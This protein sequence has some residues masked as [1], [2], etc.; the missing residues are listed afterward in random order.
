C[1]RSTESAPARGGLGGLLYTGW[2]TTS[3][4][5]SQVRCPACGHQ[6]S[7]SATYCTQCGTRLTHDAS[8]PGPAGSGSSHLPPPP[9][10]PLP[11]QSSQVGR[12]LAISGAGCVGFVLVVCIGLVLITEV[13]DPVALGLSG[14]AAVLPAVMYGSLV[15]ALDRFE[16]E[17]W[18]TVLGSFAW[19]AI[20]A[21]LF[22]Y[23]ANTIG[24]LALVSAAGENVAV[25]AQVSLVAPLVEETFKGVALLGLL[26]LIRN[27]FDNVLDG[28]VYG[29]LIGLGFAMT[30]NVIYFGRAYLETGVWGLTQLFVVR[31]VLGGLGHAMYTGTTGAALG[32]ARAQHGRGAWRFIVPIAG[33]ALAVFQHFLWNG[34]SVAIAVGLMATGQET[35][36]VWAVV[37]LQTLL[38]SVPALIVLLTIALVAGRRE[39]RIIREQLKDEVDVGV[40]TPAEYATLSDGSA[41]RRAAWEALRSGGYRHWRL[42]RRFVQAAAELAFR[43]YHISEGERLEGDQRLNSEDRYRA[44]LA[45]VRSQL[46]ALSPTP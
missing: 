28:L 26:V 41:R 22:S 14:A 38:F 8:A 35:P 16:K 42:Q 37:I 39:S 5:G 25:I 19:G 24:G 3:Q 32:W 21:T 1:D 40:L 13:P 12:A 10:L 43:K 45:A 6:N 11:Q 36:S 15:L 27:E 9:P 34:G 31:A 2:R 30:E 44:Q 46:S 23:V 18:L 33:W 20:A 29:A 7:P 4:E 17:P